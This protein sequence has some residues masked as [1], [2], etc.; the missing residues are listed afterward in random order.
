MLSD[1]GLTFSCNVEIISDSELT[2]ARRLSISTL[3]SHC[4]TFTAILLRY[5]FCQKMIGKTDIEGEDTASSSSSSSIWVR[6]KSLRLDVEEVI[7]RSLKLEAENQV[8]RMLIKF[9]IDGV[10]SGCT[11]ALH[12]LVLNSCGQKVFLSR[13]SNG[14]SEGLARK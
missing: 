7:S 5:I 9:C 12:H 11:S 6:C 10:V 1:S 2:S 8:F 14:R 3:Q 13:A 4:H